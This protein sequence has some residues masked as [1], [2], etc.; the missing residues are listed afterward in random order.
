MSRRNWILG[1]GVGMVVVLLAAG[2]VEEEGSESPD[3]TPTITDVP[4]APHVEEGQPHGIGVTNQMVTELLVEKGFDIEKDFSSAMQ[5]PLTRG[6]ASLG[7]SFTVWAAGN[8]PGVIEFSL[9]T[10]WEIESEPP[11]DAIL[12]LVDFATPHW[13]GASE[14]VSERIDELSG[15]DGVTR[16]IHHGNY[17]IRASAHTVLDNPGIQVSISPRFASCADA[18][19]AQDWTMQGSVGNQRGY[20]Q[21]RVPGEPDED[22]DH[23]VC[24]TIP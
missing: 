21:W 13:D 1:V 8:P 15:Q 7:P 22:G 5:R 19:A 4:P 16:E 12:S 9:Q 11:M 10:W 24:E 17:A 3:P 14:W 23:T 6:Y 18:L 20:A 2:C